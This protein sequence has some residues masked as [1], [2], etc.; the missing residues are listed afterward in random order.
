M[1]N[2]VDVML[3][4]VSAKA[5]VQGIIQDLGE[6]FTVY[7]KLILEYN[8]NGDFLVNKIKDTNEFWYLLHLLQ[9]NNEKHRRKLL[10]EYICRIS[11]KKLRGI[12]KPSQSG[13]DIKPVVQSLWQTNAARSNFDHSNCCRI[14]RYDRCPLRQSCWRAAYKSYEY[15]EA[16]VPE[17]DQRIDL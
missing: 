4:Q 16:K 12:I 15:I 3:S 8:L 14:R 6:E 5:V 13:K 9:I 2:T 11:I 7:E 1:G 10:G 17:N